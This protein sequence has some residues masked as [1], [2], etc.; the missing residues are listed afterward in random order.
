MYDSVR[1]NDTLFDEILRTNAALDDDTHKWEHYLWTN[2]ISVIPNTTKWFR[3]HGFIV[4][5]LRELSKDIYDDVIEEVVTSYLGERF[6]AAADIARFAILNSEG[7]FYMDM[8]FFVNAWDNEMLHYFDSV[9][10]RKEYVLNYEVLNT[11]AVLVSKGH[12]ETR[13][14]LDLT[15]SAHIAPQFKKPLQYQKCFWNTRLITFFETGSFIY[16]VAH[17]HAQ[18]KG[19]KTRDVILDSITD[20]DGP[21]TYSYKTSTGEVKQ[22]TLWFY[23]LGLGSWIDVYWDGLQF[24]FF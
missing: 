6:G 14:Y 15:R 2:D 9:H 17:I 4:R 23:E 24:G 10:F 7:G 18:Q 13:E 19:S 11:Y 16:S 3:E 20:V 22:F 21:Q 12:P 5:E 8:D 1:K